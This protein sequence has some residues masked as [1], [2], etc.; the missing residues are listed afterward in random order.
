M[1]YYS[2]DIIN[3]FGADVQE[4]KPDILII[5]GDLTTNGEKQSHLTLADKLKNIEKTSG[6]KV[7][8]IPGNHDIENPWARGFKGDERYKIDT[9]SASDF[10]KIYK[11][12]GYGEAISR[13]KDSLSYLAAPSDDVWLL[14]LDTCEYR[15]N[16]KAGIPVTNGEIKDTTLK[17]IKKCSKMA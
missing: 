2:D 13:D 12:F 1:L 17:W 3:A 15:L 4:D 8:V 7:Y 9:I 11:D 14:M 5:S 16:K 6:T 10:S